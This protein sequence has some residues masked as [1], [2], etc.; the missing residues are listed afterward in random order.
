MDYDFMILDNAF[1]VHRPGMIFSELTLTISPKLIF[2]NTNDRFAM[3][4][5]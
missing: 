3:K 2:L 1:L 4:D 5:F